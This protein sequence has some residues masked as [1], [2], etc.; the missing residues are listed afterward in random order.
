M[1]FGMRDLNQLIIKFNYDQ[2][3]KDDD[4][5]VSKSNEHIFSLLNRWPNWEKNFINIS[6]E[7]FSGK[8][9]GYDIFPEN[10]SVYEIFQGLSFIAP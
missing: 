10:R 5:Y 6:G 2:N 3:F 8:S 9:E 7:K 4:F 1:D